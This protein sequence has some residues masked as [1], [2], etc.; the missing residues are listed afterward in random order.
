MDQ[1]SYKIN[2][3][4]FFFLSFQFNL[5]FRFSFKLGFSL[6]ISQRCCDNQIYLVVL[7]HISLV[8]WTFHNTTVNVRDIN[9]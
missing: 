1:L 8:R 3:V 6:H 2:V 7:E 5:K 9:W 4:V